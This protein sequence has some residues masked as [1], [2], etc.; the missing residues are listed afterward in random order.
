MLVWCLAVCLVCSVT[1]AK[2]PE[3]QG[4]DWPVWPIPHLTF[5]ETE[6]QKTKATRAKV[7]DWQSH[8]HLQNHFSSCCPI[9]SNIFFFPV[10]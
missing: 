9:T 4:L 5:G 7:H 3:F 1:A 8:W 2:V 6:A 10:L